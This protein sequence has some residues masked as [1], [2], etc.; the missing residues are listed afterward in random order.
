MGLD[1]S[2]AAARR[3]TVH[4]SRPAWRNLPVSTGSPE[5]REYSTTMILPDGGGGFTLE[6]DPALS[7]TIA[8]ADI[9]RKA[10]LAA[11]RLR[12]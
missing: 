5:G 12:I 10:S 7:A 11:E 2:A 6:G 9:P 3:A 1:P 4:R 8:G